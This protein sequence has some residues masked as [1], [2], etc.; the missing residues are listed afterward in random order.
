MLSLHLAAVEVIKTSLDE[1]FVQIHLEASFSKNGFFN[2]SVGDEPEHND[3]FFLADTMRSVLCLQIHLR[4]PIRVKENDGV[5]CLKIQPQSSCSCTQQE[6]IV[7]GVGLIEHR[8]SLTTVIGLRAS[9][10]P[11]VLDALVLEIDLHDV[12]QMS[13]LCEDQHSVVELLEFWQNS[14]DE[15]ELSRRAEDPVMVAYV[16]VVFEEHVRMVTA[17]SQLHHQVG[18]S[19]C[20]NLA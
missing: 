6:D 20:G 3:F 12:H 8:S 9:I 18:Q 11:Q 15:L 19:C 1:K 5:G 17:F 13:H 2:G 7:L 10:Q 14:V 4:V 16:V